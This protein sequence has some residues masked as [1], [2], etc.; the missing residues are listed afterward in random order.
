MYGTDRGIRIKTN[1][2]RGS[3]IRNILVQN[4]MMDHVLCPVAINSFYRHGVSKSNQSLLDA[5]VMPVT[6]KTPLVE[7]IRISN[8]I[9]RNTRAAAGFIYGLPEMP[10]KQVSLEHITIEMTLDDQMPG[11]EPDMVREI[12]EM[13]G[14][15][16]FA[17]YVED[18]SFHHVRILTREGPAL[19][20]SHAQ[21]VRADEL[22]LDEHKEAQA[23]IEYSYVDGL[24][25][26]GTQYD[27]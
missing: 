12:I 2:E 3:Y 8:I 22:S 21:Q 1:R 4:I 19:V 26:R 13:S 17:K 27:S 5:D 9:A 25:I 14:E 23:V 10:V 16:I 20:I 18:I 6:E 24:V 15:G 11:G 7:Q